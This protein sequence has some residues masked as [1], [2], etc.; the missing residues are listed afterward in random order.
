[1]PR[2]RLTITLDSDLLDAVDTLID[3]DS[4]R[5]RSQAIE[6]YLSRGI[7]IHEMRQAFLFFSDQFIQSQLESVLSACLKDGIHSLFICTHSRNMSQASELA[8]V[9]TDFAFKRSMPDFFTSTSVPLDFGSGAAILLQ[10]AQLESA[11]LLCWFGDSFQ[12]PA[13]FLKSYLFHRNHGNP[14]TLLLRTTESLQFESCGLAIAQPEVLVAIPAGLSD[15]V[16]TVFP[17]LVKEGKVMG[18]I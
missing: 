16:D 11:F 14:V 3:G 15:L 6:H 12:S 5:N 9:I 4:L 18:Y 1:M 10:K 13:S 8:A 7:G 17:Q 2:S